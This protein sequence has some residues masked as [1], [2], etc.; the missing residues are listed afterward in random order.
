MT[1]RGSHSSAA[2]L[3]R[4]TLFHHPHLNTPQAISSGP[5]S[6]EQIDV[7]DFADGLAELAALQPPQAF[8]TANG[9][10]KLTPAG[11]MEAG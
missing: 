2:Y 11:V 8:Q 3:A 4:E 9:T 7:Q 10:W 5:L 6:I 1:D